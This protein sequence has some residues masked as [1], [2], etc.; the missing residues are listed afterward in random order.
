MKPALL[1]V[2]NVVR[3]RSAMPALYACGGPQLPHSAAQHIP[4]RRADRGRR[5]RYNRSCALQRLDLVFRTALAAGDDRTS[6]THAPAGR[7]GAAGDEPDDRL[8]AARRPEEIG[9]VLLGAAADLADHDDRFGLVV[10]KKHFEDLDKIG[11]VDR[12]AADPHA[13]RLPEA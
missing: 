3:S 5:C 7:R 9:A 11:A 10:G 12:I 8:L 1:P 6:V 4:H 2:R 13:A